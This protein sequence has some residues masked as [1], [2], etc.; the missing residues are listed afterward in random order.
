MSNKPKSHFL[1]KDIK[2]SFNKA[3]QTYDDAAF[4][5]RE[6]ADRL[7]ER[8]NYIRLQP[9]MI[10]DLGAGTGYSAHKLEQLFK[11]SKVVVFDLAEKMLLK[12][13]EQGR[14]FNRKRYICGDAEKLPFL[15][16]SMDLI[17]SN[18]VLHWT[19]NIENT[20]QEI[21]RVLK[22][23]GLLLFSTLGPDTLYELRQS[24]SV[25]DN[26]THVHPFV[27]M[28]NVGDYLQRA[29]FVDPVV[30]MEFI[31][32]TYNDLKKILLDL[33]DLGTHNIEQNR[34]KGLTGKEKFNQ[35]IQAYEKYRSPEG[36]IPV[37]YEVIYGLGWGRE[38]KKESTNEISIPVSAIKRRE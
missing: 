24:W 38:D 23:D 12:G 20:I 4:F 14:W 3:A 19:N 13:K 30:D 16:N 26:K 8:L 7:L 15:D 36:L 25:I 28:H 18:L 37:T 34:L 17:F 10:L 9:R 35:F 5:Q 33:K 2:Y 29:N 27:D 11:K 6:V 32:I 31:T 22:P 21:R 1:K